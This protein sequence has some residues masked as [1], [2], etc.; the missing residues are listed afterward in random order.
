MEDCNYA[1]PMLSF[2]KTI[3]IP[4]E[5]L[6]QETEKFIVPRMYYYLDDSDL[7]DYL[8]ANLTPVQETYINDFSIITDDDIC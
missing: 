3:Q 4:L 1:V 5:R 8:K 2:T 6:C 7:L